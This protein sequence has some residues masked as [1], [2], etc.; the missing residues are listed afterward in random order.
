MNSLPLK[1]VTF[2]E[3]EREF[4]K[5]GCEIARGLMQQ[6]LER[7]DIELAENR[8]KSK[9]RHGGKKKTTIKT[10]MGEVT[11]RR[12]IYKRVNED[13]RTEHIYLLDEAL[14]LETIGTISPNLAEKIIELSC[15]KSYRQVAQTISELTNQTISHQGVWDIIQTVGQRQTETGELT[16][17]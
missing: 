1:D 4:F 13:G 12:N 6:T 9:L 5:I 16:Y 8:N 10:M 14:G 3:L 2:K 11:I 15:Q 17:R 7:A